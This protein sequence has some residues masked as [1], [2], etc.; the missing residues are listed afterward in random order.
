MTM[1]DQLSES[2]SATSTANVRR[3]L[4]R[5][6]QDR[7]GPDLAVPVAQPAWATSFS[8][9]YKSGTTCVFVLHGN[10]NDPVQAPNG[11]FISL[12]DYLTTQ[13]FGSWQIILSYDQSRGLRPYAGQDQQRLDKMNQCLGHRDQQKSPTDWPIDP[14]KALTAIADLVDRNIMTDRF[15][16]AV[17]FPYGQFILPNPNGPSQYPAGRLVQFLSWARS[18]QIKRLNTAFVLI[19]DRL[20]DIDPRLLESPYVAS[21]EVPMPTTADRRAYIDDRT[22]GLPNLLGTAIEYTA[23]QMAQVSNGLT[24]ASLDVILSRAIKANEQIDPKTFSRLKKDMIERQCQGF[25]E[26]LEPSVTF[27]MMVGADEAVKQLKQDIDWVAHGEFALAPMGYVICGPIGCAKSFLGL[28]TAGSAG[29]PFAVLRNFRDMYVGKTEGNL[30]LVFR[31]LRCLGPLVLGVDEAD[32]SLGDRKASGDPTARRVFSM[33]ATQMADTRYRGLIIWMLMTSRPDL[34]P[35]DIKRQG[36]AEV[37]I[38]LFYPAVQDDIDKLVMAMAKKNGIV[39]DAWPQGGPTLKLGYPLSGADIESLVLSA[40]R[41]AK[42][43]GRDTVNQGDLDQAADE[44]LPSA[45]GVEKELQVLAAVLECTN[46]KFLPP[47]WREK[48]GT[49]E[50]RAALQ[51]RLVALRQLVDARAI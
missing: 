7:S 21:I 23:Q 43:A 50:K 31:V 4:D 33:F 3:A 5:I 38:P 20:A 41:L 37:H 12:S 26:F 51:E 47:E 16:V 19:A 36:R 35:I 44:F 9:L 32:A 18:V 42:S 17:M 10:V 1:A 14:D 8:N 40:R 22:R 27:D 49:P 2:G 25:V 34:L 15:G 28:C 39:W 46:K 6:R 24:L 48:A 13:I 30:E 11:S 29:I 45:Q